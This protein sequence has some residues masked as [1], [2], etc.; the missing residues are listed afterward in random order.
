MSNMSWQGLNGFVPLIIGFSTN[1]NLV[2]L[3]IWDSHY[4]LTDENLFQKL[5]KVEGVK[6]TTAQ[7]GNF[8][9]FLSLRFYVKSK[10]ANLCTIAWSRFLILFHTMPFY[11]NVVALNFD[12]FFL[13]SFALLEEW[14]GV[15]Q[16]IKICIPKNRQ[17]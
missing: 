10:L 5:Y 1:P 14:N 11:H 3:T 8:R 2:R 4:F 16:I 12:Y 13:W 6:N 7:C 9:I 17:C 15:D